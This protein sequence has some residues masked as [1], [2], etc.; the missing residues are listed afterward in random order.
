[1]AYNKFTL[2]KVIEQFGVQVVAAQSLFKHEIEKVEISDI[3]KKILE[4]NF[5]LVRSFTSEKALSELLIS[6]ILV[7]LRELRQQQINIFS[8]IEFNID[9][10]RGL[11]G[12][13]DFIIGG[14]NSQFVLNAP[15]MTIVE[16][17]KGVIDYG[18][19]QC[20]A[21]MIAATIFNEKRNIQRT[22]YGCV[23][24]GWDWKFMFIQ[25]NT[26]YIEDK[27]HS[28]NQLEDVLAYLSEMT[29]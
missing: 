28:I 24:T 20:V 10:T 12:H 6:P 16:A 2:E 1:M 18:Y 17:K 3:L 29:K 22:V 27:L 25:E 11:R 14:N 8:G 5:P 4:R 15:V 13:C 26:V 19:G 21:E 9:A 23:T 7:E